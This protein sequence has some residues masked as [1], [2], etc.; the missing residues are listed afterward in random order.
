MGTLSSL[1]SLLSSLFP[2]LVSLFSLLSS[3][4]SLL[5]S[6]FSLL[7]SLFSLLLL[8]L[9]LIHMLVIISLPLAPHTHYYC[10][11]ILVLLS[12]HLELFLA[13]YLPDHLS[14]PLHPQTQNPNR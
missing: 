3:L 14:T 8:L 9:L 4:F 6:L 7:S 2:L 5:S 1:F 10:W 11:L 12:Y 13:K